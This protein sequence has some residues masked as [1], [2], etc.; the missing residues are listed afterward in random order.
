MPHDWEQRVAREV[1]LQS[2]IEAAFDRADACERLGDFEQALEWLDR[3][4]RLSGGLSLTYRD[5]R[6]DFARQIERGGR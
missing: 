1:E 2:R 5:R 4:S 3:A 6:A